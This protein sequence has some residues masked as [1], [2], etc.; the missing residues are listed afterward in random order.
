MSATDE[1]H[2]PKVPAQGESFLYLFD[3][4]R[5]AKLLAHGER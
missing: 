3:F 5:F 2:M 4:D 1:W